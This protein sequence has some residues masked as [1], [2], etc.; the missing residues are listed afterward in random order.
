M[1]QSLPPPTSS[2]SRRFQALLE[3]VQSGTKSI[4]LAVMKKGEP[5]MMIP[6]DRMEEL[7]KEIEAD[8]EAE[9]E[10]KKKGKAAAK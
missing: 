4:E 6:A 1:A 2:T 8:R 7:F 10:A 3:V 9:A 5:L